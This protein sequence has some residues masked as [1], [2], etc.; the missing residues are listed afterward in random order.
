MF[1]CMEVDD[2]EM[3]LDTGA[4]PHVHCRWHDRKE[5]DVCHLSKRVVFSLH[6]ESNTS[7]HFNFYNWINDPLLIEILELTA[8]SRICML[9][10]SISPLCQRTAILEQLKHEQWTPAYYS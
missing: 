1:S 9:D 4:L 3:F 7:N 5:V 10:I 8:L 2:L 6:H